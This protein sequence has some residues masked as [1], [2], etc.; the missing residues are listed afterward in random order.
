MKLLI[1]VLFFNLAQAQMAPPSFRGNPPSEDGGVH[2]DGP[3][4]DLEQNDCI[5]CRPQPTGTA[6]IADLSSQIDDI[7]NTDKLEAIINSLQE[8]EISQE[9]I[10]Q[11]M[12]AYQKSKQGISP[13]TIE[14]SNEEIE[15][16][17]KKLAANNFVELPNF[18]QQLLY[19]SPKESV[20]EQ[21]VERPSTEVPE[22]EEKLTLFTTTIQSEENE[23]PEGHKRP[24]ERR[25][26]REQG[27]NSGERRAAPNRDSSSTE[28]TQARTSSSNISGQN[29]TQNTGNISSMSGYGTGMNSMSGYGTGMNSMSGYGTGMNS[30]SGYGTGMNSM[31]G[32]GTGMNSMSGY[33]TGM[34]S[35][36]GYGTGMNSMYGYGTGMNSMYGYGTGMNSMYGYGTGMNSMYGY[37][38][39]MNSM[40]GYGTGMNSMYG[41]GTGMNSMYGYGTGMNSMYGYGTGMN[42]MYGYGTGMNSNMNFNFGY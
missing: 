16:I 42:S 18:L 37:G 13:E 17:K 19:P 29:S 3:P 15:I 2:R 4:R 10:A 11:L 5:D 24:P 30:M 9:T 34:N 39:G 35:M 40:Y 27:D 20:S 12:D 23:R 7:T 8:K 26:T 21:P 1:L 22:R 33:G 32:Y 25:P 28:Q 6:A 14:L 38:T 36:Y 41:Y 31:Y